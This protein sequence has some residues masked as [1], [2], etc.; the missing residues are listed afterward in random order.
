MF[1]FAVFFSAVEIANRCLVDVGTKGGGP[2]NTIAADNKMALSQFR[3]LHSVTDAEHAAALKQL[4]W[5]PEEYEWGTKKDKARASAALKR[6]SQLMANKPHTGGTTTLALPSIAGSTTGMP[7]SQRAVLKS[8]SADETGARIAS[9]MTQAHPTSDHS[10]SPDGLAGKLAMPLLSLEQANSTNLLKLPNEH[11]QSID[12]QQEAQQAYAK[13]H[14]MQQQQQQKPR[15]QTLRETPAP[16][17][18]TTSPIPGVV[19]TTTKAAADRSA[20]HYATVG[21]SSSLAERSSATPTHSP[22]TKS[23]LEVI[24]ARV[25][26]RAKSVERKLPHSVHPRVSLSV[27]AKQMARRADQSALERLADL[28]AQPSA[29]AAAAA[30]ASANQKSVRAVRSSAGS[31]SGSNR[32]SGV[33]IDYASI[34]RNS[35]VVDYGLTFKT[36]NSLNQ[37]TQGQDLA[38]AA[39]EIAMNRRRA[40]AAN[41]AAS[42]S[43]GSTDENPLP[44]PADVLYPVLSPLGRR[45]SMFESRPSVGTPMKAPDNET[46]SQFSYDGEVIASV[47]SNQHVGNGTKK[48]NQVEGNS[49]GQNAP[50][51]PRSHFRRPLLSDVFGPLE[52]EGTAFSPLD[53]PLPSRNEHPMVPAH[54][55]AADKGNCSDTS[56]RPPA[57]GHR[58]VLDIFSQGPPTP[59]KSSFSASPANFSSATNS[60]GSRSNTTPS[61]IE[62]VVPKDSTPSILPVPVPVVKMP[63]RRTF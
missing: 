21:S 6:L 56:T 7:D 35:N 1:V 50:R 63:R 20:H 43:T 52:E 9:S 5:T 59:A 30:V 25:T 38:A 31:S 27:S 40:Q 14:Q 13:A 55:N 54:K 24:A 4:G 61:F 8:D 36:W 32:R 58:S 15:Y 60:S 57:A 18:D 34:G 44:N 53:L 23:P 48:P 22:V 3:S 45:R 41:T 47:S 16:T 26:P 10:D 28:A 33:V 2:D 51:T 29:G 11:T 49:S 42:E 39:R 17:T 62:T 46:S 37:G 12:L 19:S